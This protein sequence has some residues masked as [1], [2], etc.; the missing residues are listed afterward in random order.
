MT[1]SPAQYVAV[2][3]QRDFTVPFPFINR[4]HVEVLVNGN[5][6]TVLE[7]PTSSIVRLAAA[8][9]GGESVVIQRRTPIDEALVKFQNGAVLT[10]EDL[11]LAVQQ[12]LYRQ[13]ESTALV[14]GSLRAAQ[15]RIA[16]NL[17]VVT[18][19]TDVAQELAELVLEQEV[20]NNFRQRIADIDLNASQ[21]TSQALTLNR[22]DGDFTILRGDHDSLVGV[23]DSLLGGDPGTGIATLIQNETNERIAGDQAL[24]TTLALIGARSGDNLSF[25]L[26]T[27]KVRVSPTESLAQRFS[28]LVAADSNALAAIQS[29][30]TARINADGV[31]TSSVNSLGARMGTAE[32]AI[33]NEQNAR[34]AGDTAEA[35]ARSALAA[36]VGTAEATILSDR[37]ARIDGDN[38]LASDLSLIG[39]KTANGQGWLLDLNKVQVSPTQSLATRLSGIDAQLNGNAAAIINE[40]TARANADSALSQQISVVSSQVGPLQASVSTLS[41]SVDGIRARYGVSL[42]VNGYVTGFVQNNDGATGT[43]DILADRFRV[44]A[45]GVAP[46]TVFEVDAQGVSMSGNVRINGNLLVAQTI[47]TPAL[48]QNSV[49]TSAYWQ[50]AFGGAMINFTQNVWVDFSTATGGGSG[51]GGGGSGGGGG[52]EFEVNLQ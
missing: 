29:E 24:A 16:Q 48:Q 35:N 41:Q 42:D 18:N 45:P 46:R 21:I 36:R 28:A 9:A 6:A 44:V 51:G 37:Q 50:T 11:N 30:E 52:G 8:L 14:E 19:P 39:A 1:Y 15:V 17:G 5:L 33:V 13:Q 47:Q 25:I 12:L 49:S 34:I 23:V 3:G 38:A 40:A 7:W 2:S 32:A 27:T 4:T 22:L 10:E 43:F 31:L 26:D 20:L